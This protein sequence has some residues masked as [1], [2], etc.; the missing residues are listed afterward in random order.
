[1]AS[2]SFITMSAF[3]HPERPGAGSFAARIATSLYHGFLRV[4]RQVAIRQARRELLELPD[5]MLKDMGITRSEIASVVAFG[6]TD[7]TRILH[8]DGAMEG[9]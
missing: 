7:E 5:M 6:R 4:S 9:P 2:T 8:F 1:M 3:P